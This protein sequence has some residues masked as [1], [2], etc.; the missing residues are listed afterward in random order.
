MRPLA[1]PLITQSDG[2][3]ENFGVANMHSVIR[4]T[5]D[6]SLVGS[7]QHRFKKHKF[8]IKSEA[9]WS[10]FRRDF[11]PGYERLFQLGIDEGWYDPQNSYQ[12]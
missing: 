4:Q 8:N 7:L 1:V 6:N 12:R 9:N 10:V 2:G 5:M 11:S 3:S